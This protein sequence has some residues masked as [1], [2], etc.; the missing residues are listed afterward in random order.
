MAEFMT[1]LKKVV[2][3]LSDSF[4]DRQTGEVIA[5]NHLYCVFPRK[6]ATGAGAECVKISSRKENLFEGLNIGDYV[7]LRYNKYG[8]CCGFDVVEPNSD[9]ESDFKVVNDMLII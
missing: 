1:E 4:T 8:K 5:Y 6:N 2:G 3:F 7:E 9:D